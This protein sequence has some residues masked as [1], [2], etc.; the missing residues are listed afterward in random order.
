ML[1]DNSEAFCERAQFS[2][3]T[4]PLMPIGGVH[5]AVGAWARPTSRTG[6]KSWA[7]KWRERERQRKRETER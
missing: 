2:L 4:P 7:L 1:N 6:I 3:F 5:L